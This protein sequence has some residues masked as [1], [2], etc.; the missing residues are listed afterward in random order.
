SITA[1][2]QMATRGV[3]ARAR[4]KSSGLPFNSSLTDIAKSAGLTAPVIYGGVDRSDYIIEAIGC[5]A[6][7]FDYD[8]D[9]WL[10]ILLLTGTRWDGAPPGATT[11]L[12]KNNRNGTFTD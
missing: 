9:G 1:R 10:D 11:R 3:T 6:A 2:A 7:F 5:G 4:G 8:N 12:Y